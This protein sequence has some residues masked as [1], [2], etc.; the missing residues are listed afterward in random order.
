V[1]YLPEQ[2]ARHVGAPDMS[3]ETM[4]EAGK[5]CLDVAL[6]TRDDEHYAAGTTH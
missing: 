2:A 1:P 6:T 5:L 3:L 4:I